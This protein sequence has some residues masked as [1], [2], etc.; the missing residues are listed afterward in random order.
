MEWRKITMTWSICSA[1]MKWSIYPAL[2]IFT[3]TLLSSYSTKPFWRKDQISI[4]TQPDQYYSNKKPLASSLPSLDQYY[5]KRPLASLLPNTIQPIT[6]S[7]SDGQTPPYFPTHCPH[8]SPR[9]MMF[10]IL[11]PSFPYFDTWDY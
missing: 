10:I 6:L 9:I 1:S 4:F 5:S 2:S 11:H 8:P 7:K 3:L